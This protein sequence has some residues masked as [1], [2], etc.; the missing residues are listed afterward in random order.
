MVFYINKF[1][2]FLLIL[3]SYRLFKKKCIILKNPN[4][5][6]KLHFLLRLSAI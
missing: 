3:S 1:G 4:P 2:T 6:N 5:N